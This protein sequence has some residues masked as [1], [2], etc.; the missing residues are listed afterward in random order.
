MAPTPRLPRRQTQRT[1]QGAALIMVLVLLLLV[2]LM[3]MGVMR[4]SLTS[5]AITINARSQTLATE[6][7]QLAL[8]FCEEDIKRAFGSS[9]TPL[10]FSKATPILEKAA[11]EEAMAWRDKDN[12]ADGTGAAKTLRT[13]HL[14]SSVTKMLPA[15]NPQCLAEYSPVD[16]GAGPKIIVLTARGFSPDYS[17]DDADKAIVAGSVVWLQSRFVLTSG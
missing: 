14:K 12:W 3:S 8:R 1:Q 17:E 9:T 13:E 16:A 4:T 10:L 2:I 15:K 5:D 11:T 6:M 7:A